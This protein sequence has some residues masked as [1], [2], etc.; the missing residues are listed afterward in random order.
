MEQQVLLNV[1]EEKF[2]SA[3]DALRNKHVGTHVTFLTE[4]DLDYMTRTF[5]EKRE[6]KTRGG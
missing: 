2:K 6:Q 3:M 5:A 4:R 1:D